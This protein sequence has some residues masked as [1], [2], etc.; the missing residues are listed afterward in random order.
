MLINISQ[1]EK[2]HAS[3]RMASSKTEIIV[4]LVINHARHARELTMMNAQLVLIQKLS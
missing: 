1:V 2:D 3:A 4:R